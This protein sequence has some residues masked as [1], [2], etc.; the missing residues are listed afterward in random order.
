MTLSEF[1]KA[2]QTLGHSSKEPVEKRDALIRL[3]HALDC[4]DPTV[5]EHYAQLVE[6][7][8]QDYAAHV[9]VHDDE[10]KVM[11]VVVAPDGVIGLHNHPKQYGFIGCLDG[12]VRIDCYD[13]VSHGEVYGQ[14]RHCAALRLSQGDFADLT[15]TE[16]N[17]HRIQGDKLA[18]LVDVFLPPLMDENHTLCRRYVDPP[19]SNPGDMIRAQI[20]PRPQPS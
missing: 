5:R 15:P 8:F 11:L 20:I 13:E 16:R 17:F 18:L 19:N 2:C 7:G 3:F 4:Y 6:S 1:I 12:C 14:L 9:L 10:C